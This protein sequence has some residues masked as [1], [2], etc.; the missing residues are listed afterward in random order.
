MFN[1]IDFACV[2]YIFYTRLI[3]LSYDMKGWNHRFSLYETKKVRFICVSYTFH[4]YLIK[5]SSF[6]IFFG[7][8]D[9]CFIPGVVYYLETETQKTKKKKGQKYFFARWKEMTLFKTKINSCWTTKV[10]TTQCSTTI[11]HFPN[12]KP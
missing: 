11:N 1:F 12:R 2:S 10:C 6:Y 5:K 9:M 7:S 8:F 4:I 3:Y